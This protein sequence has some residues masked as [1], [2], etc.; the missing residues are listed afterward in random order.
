MS[1]IL[2]C[3]VI[4]YKGIQFKIPDLAAYYKDLTY[5]PADILVRRW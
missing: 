3:I 5:L 1:K 2:V 4:L